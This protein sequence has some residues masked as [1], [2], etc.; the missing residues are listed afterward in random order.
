VVI[1]LLLL[2]LG[3]A[4]LAVA[5]DR[6][7][8][9]AAEVAARMRVSTIVTGA[10]IVGFGTS[11]PELVVSSLATLT[12]G[13][14]GTSLAM[15]NIIGS[16]VANL[17]LVLAIPVLVVGGIGLPDRSKR[18]VAFSAIG[19]TIFA[20]LSRFGE[21]STWKGIG[22]A[23]L[24]VAA[25]VVIVGLRDHFGGTPPADT[26]EGAG[27]WILTVFGLVGTVVFAWLVVESATAIADHMGWTGGFV[28]F[29][30]V[31]LG[32]SLPELS[33][34]MAAARRAETGLIMGNLLGSNLFNSL[35]VGS[36][37]FLFNGS[38]SFEQSD[39]LLGWGLL[40]MVAVSWGIIIPFGTGSRI[41]RYEAV[42]LLAVYIG[43]LVFMATNFAT[44]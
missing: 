23:V 44:V 7:V 22:L 14:E 1:D 15:G 6:F 37:V 4:G 34:V 8:L 40:T 43:L 24:A 32:T 30:L 3:L 27:P 10:L 18:Q 41:V 36:A 29:A 5:A 19:V 13:A 11:A 17:T 2:V 38:R 33:T 31:A 21:P 26:T 39:G 9:G 28:G 35:T 20:V 42:V 25:L 12:E 16:N